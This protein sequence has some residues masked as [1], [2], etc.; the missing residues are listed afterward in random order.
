[1]YESSA[2]VLHLPRRHVRMSPRT[3]RRRLW[4]ALLSL[5]L[6][7]GL[8][9]VFTGIAHGEDGPAYMTVTVAPGDTLW[10]IAAH[11]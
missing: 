11:R 1:M 10:D 8:S 5:T 2:C 3:R 7:V 6:V 4:L 9:L